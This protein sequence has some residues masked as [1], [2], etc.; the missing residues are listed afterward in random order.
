MFKNTTMKMKNSILFIALVS[1]IWLGGC[2]SEPKIVKG[3]VSD[4]TLLDI[5]QAN[6]YTE[7]VK[8]VKLAGLE[9]QINGATKQ[10]IFAPDNAAFNVL[11][12]Q[13]GLNKVD[14]INPT[15]LASVLR[16]HIT[17]EDSYLAAS[18]PR[19]AASL[20]GK[21]FYLTQNAASLNALGT[22]VLKDRSAK[23]GIFHGIN[24]VLSSPTLSIYDAIAARAAGTPP[25]FTLLKYAIDR[26]GLDGV[27]KSGDFTLFAPTN[28]AFTTAGLGT[29]A[30]LD[31]VA[32]DALKTILQY[33]VLPTARFS[34]ELTTGRVATANGPLANNTKGIDINA[35]TPAFEGGTISNADQLATNGVWHQIS[36]VARPKVGI[37]EGITVPGVVLT[38]SGNDNAGPDALGP[39]VTAS[40]YT[41]FDDINRS[42]KDAVY[43][44]R[45]PPT[46]GSFPNN[47]EIIK[48]LERHIF[49]STVNFTTATNGTK[50]T[51]VGGNEYYVVVDAAGGRYINGVAA[52]RNA[53]GATSTTS[54]AA[55]D[56]VAYV[57]GTTGY[58]GLVPL[59]TNN[60]VQQLD[61]DAQFTL[62]A[63]AIKKVGRE[64]SLTSG[65]KTFFAV[66]NAAFTTKTG[67]SSV[68][69]INALA[70]GDALLQ[71]ITTLIDKHTVN[72]AEFAL[73]LTSAIP[74]LKN[75]LDQDVTFAVVAGNVVVIDDKQRPDTKFTSFTTTDKF[76]AKNGVVHVVS[77]FFEF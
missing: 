43:F 37:K 34:I 46:A 42:S 4:K 62:I 16:Y 28:A 19:K 26:A 29:T 75:A 76:L 27:L 74:I 13:L 59:P 17:T 54:Y 3:T 48:Y 55:Y 44:P 65:N 36:A 58:T 1:I 7:F 52:S 56:G 5:I 41:R 73:R 11:L 40:G 45:V 21:S 51:S 49:A 2:D 31:G 47:Q 71:T 77:K 9:A 60:I 22:I 8:A 10:T 70:A 69:Q 63:A 14:E 50:V 66:A 64:A 39:L 12:K 72:S 61:G 57:W 15:V 67:L 53:F 23:N 33:H 38:T 68:S 30:A 24:L 6:G 35:T 32:V 25:Q 18:L 20:D